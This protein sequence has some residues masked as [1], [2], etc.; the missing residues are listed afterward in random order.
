VPVL[1][2]CVQSKQS[3]ESIAASG[4]LVIDNDGVALTNM[5]EVVSKSNRKPTKRLNLIPK[6]KSTRV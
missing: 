5:Q 3:H 1:D 6:A 2:F 4:Q